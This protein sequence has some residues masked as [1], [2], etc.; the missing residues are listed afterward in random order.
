MAGRNAWWGIGVKRWVGDQQRMVGAWRVRRQSCKEL[1]NNGVGEIRTHEGLA[2]LAVFKTAAF[3]HSATTP[4]AYKVFPDNKLFKHSA[5][6][7][8]SS[9][10]SLWMKSWITR[11]RFLVP[12]P[13][14]DGG[15]SAWHGPRPRDRR[16]P[17]YSRP[18]A[19]RRPQ[20]PRWESGAY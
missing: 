9:G 7:W 5:P 16:T 20:S 17:S 18:R 13:W 4:D 12:R 6:G 15:G 8:S 3:N 2:P 1:R 14:R 19:L 10:A 11:T